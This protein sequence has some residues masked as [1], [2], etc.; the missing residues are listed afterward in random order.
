MPDDVI[1][2]AVVLQLQLDPSDIAAASQC[3][4]M[5]ADGDFVSTAATLFGIQPICL[6]KQDVVS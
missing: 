1:G 5:Y 6:H 3:Y 4:A 2:D